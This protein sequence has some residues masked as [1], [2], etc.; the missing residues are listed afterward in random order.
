[1]K[2]SADTEEP[3]VQRGA[4]QRDDSPPP[5]EDRSHEA[6]ADTGPRVP[7]S[8]PRPFGLFAG[9]I[10]IDPDFDDPLP[11]EVTRAFAGLGR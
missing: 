7:G 3:G 9:E 8:P 2:I 10:V 11:A 1:M 4:V 6:A 5:A